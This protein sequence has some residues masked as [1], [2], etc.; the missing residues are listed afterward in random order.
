MNREQLEALDKSEIIDILLAVLDELAELKIQLNVYKN[1]NSTNSSLPPSSDKFKTKSLRKK[2][3]KKPGGQKGHTG[4]HLAITAEPDEIVQVK[5]EK[6]TN[7]GTDLREISGTITDDIR[8]KIDIE[9]ITKIT[10]YEQ[11]EIICPV[12]KIAN[13]GVFPDGVNSYI[14]YGDSVRAV[15]VVLNNYAM[16]SCDKTSKIM[17]DIFNI[18][19]RTGTIVNHTKSFAKIAKPAAGEIPE[20]LINSA[21]ANF[22]ETGTSMNGKKLWIHNASNNQATWVTVHPKRG[23]D[24]IDA[25]GVIKRF[26]GV[27]V[28]DRWSGYALKPQ[29]GDN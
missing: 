17:R 11:V 25:N 8:Y 26:C 22:D 4:S 6:C 1:M 29:C 28:H 5:P 14:Q 24:G 16:V 18:P 3:G 9:I 15:S 19:I 21:L 27:A 20:K 23:K 13:R 10:R 12:C 2:S 7:C